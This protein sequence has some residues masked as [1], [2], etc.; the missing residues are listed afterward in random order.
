MDEPS[1]TAKD[2]LVLWWWVVVT[3]GA[4]RNASF[5]CLTEI[6][7]E[8]SMCVCAASRKVGGDAWW[9]P[10]F[11][12][13]LSI[14]R[15]LRDHHL[16]FGRGW[17]GTPRRRW[18]RHRR[19]N[20]EIYMRRGAWVKSPDSSC[21]CCVHYFFPTNQRSGLSAGRWDRLY[22]EINESKVIVQN[23]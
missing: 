3:A 1:T 10:S 8:V 22:R 7:E 9:I 21:C 14:Y 18:I 4:G 23:A 12:L 13:S 19:R 6:L 16:F 2:P 5:H 20:R 11:P 17:R 15:R